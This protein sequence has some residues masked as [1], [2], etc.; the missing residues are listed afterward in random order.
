[1]IKIY[2][3]LLSV[4]FLSA[5]GEHKMKYGV[6]SVAGITSY[7]LCERAR[8]RI[9]DMKRASFVLSDFVREQPCRN[10]PD[11]SLWMRQ[12][13]VSI[14]LPA[15]IYSGNTVVIGGTLGLEIIGNDLY[16]NWHYY[17][18]PVRMLDYYVSAIYGY[19]TSKHL[20]GQYSWVERAGMRC[21]RLHVEG[22]GIIRSRKM[23]Y[24]CYESVSGY[25]FPIHL[26]AWERLPAGSTG[27]SDFEKL[28]IGPVLDSMEIQPADPGTL[29]E[30]Y[31][32]QTQKCHDAKLYYDS[33]GAEGKRVGAGINQFFNIHYLK[34]CGYDID[35]LPD[36]RSIHELVIRDGKVIGK[37]GQER[38][39]KVFDDFAFVNRDVFNKHKNMKFPEDVRLLS[40]DE[41]NWLKETLL[42]LRPR[43]IQPWFDYPGN[44][45]GFSQR[46][47]GDFGLRHDADFGEVIDMT[48]RYGEHPRLSFIIN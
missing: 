34:D 31:A 44:W 8:Q 11:Y 37:P 26:H 20:P 12:D 25:P 39:L 43:I 40:K 18:D 2:C 14:S 45:Y 21:L 30:Y 33:L 3:L 9:T 38:H 32:T 15:K 24:F 48:D 36:V 10:W 6:S 42:Q 27:G 17:K 29:A 1:M 23:D 46:K 7:P 47:D 13:Q 41:F 16:K 28:L 35:E 22:E 19:R 5:C 4:L